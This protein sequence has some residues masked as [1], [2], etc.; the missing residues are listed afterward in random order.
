MYIKWLTRTYV[1]GGKPAE[2][3]ETYIS[4]DTSNE[5]FSLL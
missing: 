5:S 1:M 3:W 2:A 4:M